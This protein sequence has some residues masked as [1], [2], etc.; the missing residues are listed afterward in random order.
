MP[1]LRLVITALV[2]TLGSGWVLHSQ[3]RGHVVV[4]SFWFDESVAFA[5]E[6]FTPARGG[7]ALSITEIGHVEAVA[8]RELR[9]AFTGLRV[10]FIAGRDAMYRVRVVQQLEPVPWAPLPRMLA[11]AGESRAVRPIGGGGA[12]SFRVLADNAVAYAPPGAARTVVLDGIGRGLGRAAAHEFAHQFFP[13]AQFHVSRDVAS[14]EFASAA[15]AEQYYGHL[16]WDVAWPLLAQRFG[17]ITTGS[18]AP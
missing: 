11:A 6:G 8:R 10:R 13:S 15:R 2:I 4:G 5:I 16:H 14:Y 9:A 7:G 17:P 3:R 12:V 18:P 1:A